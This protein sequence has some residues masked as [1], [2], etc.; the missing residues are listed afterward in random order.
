[1]TKRISAAFAAI[2]LFSACQG[3]GGPTQ[4]P[5]PVRTDAPLASPTGTPLPQTSATAVPTTPAAPPTV[6]ATTAA[7]PT[8]SSITVTGDDG[9]TVTLASAPQRVV[10]LTPATT[11][12]MFELGAGDRLVGRTDY[13]DYPPEASQVPPVATFQGVEM[14]KV[15]NIGPD[16][17]LAGGNNFTSQADIDK[18]RQLGYPVLVL[19]A[20]DVAGVLADI[21]LVGQAVGESDTAAHI[22]DSIQG[23]IDEVS[24]AVASLSKPRTFYEIGDDPELYGPAPDSFVA[25]E[26]T[27]AGGDPITTTDPAVFSIPL[28]RLVSEDPEVIVLGDAAYGTCPSDV[29][30]R[31]GWKKITAVEKQAVV[32]VDDTIVTRPGPRIG[33]GLAALAL[34]IHPDAQITPPADVP[35]YCS[36]TPSATP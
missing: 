2:I 27:L 20:Q 14:E 1:M 7:S 16:L 34:A 33:E 11:E 26:V 10:S 13:D 30:G 35:V 12:L 18:M 24:T 31:A 9:T 36:A 23:R 29:Y 21:S 25:D 28:E 5:A 17:V 19:Y 22:N 32:P 8:S 6:L 15:V 4:T 3:A